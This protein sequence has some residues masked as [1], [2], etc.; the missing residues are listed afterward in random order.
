MTTQL[1]Q[2]QKTLDFIKKARLVHGNI[3]VYSKAIFKN[4][5]TNLIIECPKHGDFIQNPHNHIHGNGCPLCGREKMRKSH[6]LTQ[7]EFIEKASWYTE[8][9]MNIKKYFM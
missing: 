6:T 3:Y 8:T 1:V 5:R 9:P 4:R 2:N 7:E